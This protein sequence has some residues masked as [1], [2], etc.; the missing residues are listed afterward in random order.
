MTPHQL[1][2]RKDDNLTLT[3]PI[4]FPEAALGAEVKVPTLDGGPVTLKIPA[5]TTNGRTFRIRGKGVT[6]KDGSRGDQLV[7]V[8]VAV[9]QKLDDKAREALEKF[10]AATS[11]DDPRAG[12]LGKGSR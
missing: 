12:L 7:T 6:R 2:G 8:D 1:F 5:G 3:V 4:T 9:P 10:R 11:G